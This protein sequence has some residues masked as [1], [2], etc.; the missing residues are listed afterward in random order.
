MTRPT[1][2][3]AANAPHSHA[4]SPTNRA[5]NAIQPLLGNRNSAERNTA[6]RTSAVST[7]V[8]SMGG[9]AFP[10]P[11]RESL[12][13]PPAHAGFALRFLELPAGAAQACLPPAKPRE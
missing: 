5:Q 4:E 2:A 10:P 9:R 6:S 12:C 13:D 3:R 7:R 8:F 11:W 1:A